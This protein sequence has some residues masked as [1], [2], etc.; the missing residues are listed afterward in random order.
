M[1][2]QCVYI[3]KYLVMDWRMYNGSTETLND[4]DGSKLLITR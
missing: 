3:M 2:L 4:L 1:I